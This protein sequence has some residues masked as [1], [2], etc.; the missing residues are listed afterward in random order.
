MSKIASIHRSRDV[1]TVFISDVHLGFPGCSAEYLCDFLAQVR[2]RELF[3][4]GDIID[5]WY[6]RK[7]RHW[8]AAHSRV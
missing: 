3:L 4:V 2:C 5:F 8:P 6:L 7:R 1:R